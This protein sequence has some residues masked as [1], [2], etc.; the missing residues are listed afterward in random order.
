[1][2]NIAVHADIGPS[3]RKQFLRDWHIA[4]A[5]GN[6]DF[7]AESVTDDVRLETVGDTT[8]EGAPA[9]LDALRA[10]RESAIVELVV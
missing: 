5:Q 8:T 2:P 1:M 3:P 10:R 7:I 6:L 9:L 4:Y